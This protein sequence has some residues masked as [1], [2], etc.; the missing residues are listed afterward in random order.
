MTDPTSSFTKRPIDGSA[1][2]N[3]GASMTLTRQDLLG[4]TAKAIEYAQMSQRV[5]ALLMV[6]LIRPDKLD[7]LVGIPTANVTRQAQL[8]LPGA[9]RS[10]DRFVAVTDDK[11]AVLLP[12]L[13]STAQSLL[14]AEKLQRTLEAD[15][16]FDGEKVSV[17]PVIGVATFPDNATS[18]EE[19]LIHADIATSIASDREDAHHVYEKHDAR[20]VEKYLGLEA[21]LREAMRTGSLRLAYQPQIHLK[22]GKCESVEALIR[23]EFEERGPI[24][25][26]T[27]VRIAEA[28]GFIGTL[29]E[30]V[31]NSAL[32]Q[33]AEWMRNGVLL[34]LS[35]NLS[36]INL[37]D[38]DLPVTVRHCLGTWG[39]D[40]ADITLEI[41]ESVSVDETQRSIALL[42]Q[43]RDLGL[44]LSIDDFG[45]GY[46][47]LSYVKTFPLNE[48]K[49]DK[50]FI[51]DM[52]H[53]RADQQIT[54]AIIDLAHQ[55]D[56]RVV[57][58][59]VEDEATFRE[60]KKMGCDVAQ[61]YFIAP[62]M[63]ADELVAWLKR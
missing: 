44:N 46:S 48:I 29:T 8:R 40:P 42:Q 52:R 63:P 15:F 58:E 45:T 21:P 24:P 27:I 6:H 18:A 33:H 22:T 60:L 16:A 3:D 31:I 49:I 35:I 10:V 41:T 26:D 39:N 7:A 20:H 5:C 43:I 55:F 59:G 2:D 28:N 4:A 9:L 61:G 50:R 23:W 47:S 34:G 62:A 1:P 53:S 19:L 30:W 37:Q 12:N 51:Q 13:R 14:A 56:L 32:R 11:I 54:K 38:V 57:A 17:R 25:A 36:S